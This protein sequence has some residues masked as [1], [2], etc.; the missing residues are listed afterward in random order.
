MVVK[1]FSHFVKSPA[2]FGLVMLWLVLVFL[3]FYVSFRVLIIVWLL[4]FPPQIEK[5]YAN[6]S[7]TKL[8]LSDYANGYQKP[9]I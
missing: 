5:I 6:D 4:V 3:C 9:K 8:R 7:I 1:T 2:N